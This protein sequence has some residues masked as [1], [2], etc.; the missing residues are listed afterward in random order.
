MRSLHRGNGAKKIRFRLIAA[1][2]LVGTLGAV[3]LLGTAMTSFA[4]RRPDGARSGAWTAPLRRMD[5]A[6]AAGD[7]RLAERA[8]HDAYGQALG[9]RRWEGMVEA[10]D[11][12]LT[13]RAVA[14]DQRLAAPTAR[15]AYLTALVRAR[16]LGSVDG[17]LRTAEAFARLGDGEVVERALQVARDL[18]GVHPEAEA[19][20]HGLV[21][22]C[23]EAAHGSR[24]REF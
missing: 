15:R 8:W 13:I 22:L 2:V 4:P 1:K 20:I 7:I 19:R 14:K 12:A 23:S 3:L 5:E 17:V 16:D 21:D 24:K 9:S 11:A 18:G 10:G 6:L